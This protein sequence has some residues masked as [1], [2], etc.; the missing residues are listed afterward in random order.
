[1]S[2][3][4]RR[5]AL[6][7]GIGIL[8]GWLSQVQ[9][10]P[11]FA[12]KYEMACK[13]CHM[14]WPTLNEFGR[15]FKMNGYR[16]ES[17]SAAPM[18]MDKRS[19]NLWVEKLPY[20]SAR[21]IGNIYNKSKGDRRWALQPAHE[22]ELYLTG[23][24]ANDVSFFAEVEAEDEAD[25]NVALEN[26]VVGWHPREEANILGGW[27]SIFFADPFN[28]LRDGGGRLTVS[29]K[30]PLDGGFDPDVTG[31]TQFLTFN[32]RTHGLYYSASMGAGG[33]V[34]NEGHD[35]KDYAL[36]LAYSFPMVTFG[37][38]YLD[39]STDLDAVTEDDFT[40]AGLDFLFQKGNWQAYGLW[41][42]TED[43]EWDFTTV[44][45]TPLDEQK[46]TAG[47]VEGMYIFTRAD[48]DPFIVPLV[49]YETVES[50]DGDDETSSVI[51]AVKAYVRSNVDIYLEY[52]KQT[53]V[54]DIAPGVEGEKGRRLTLRANLI[55]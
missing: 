17:G 20:L 8:G 33:D 50:N 21:L 39:G 30:S 51:A 46:N 23:N 55:F 28:T 19:E 45:P 41:M 36:R 53:K 11:A 49:R 31:S 42:T 3:A 48:G 1:M 15:D 52:K 5:L 14:P 22:I 32:G 7:L 13:Q 2:L 4:M 26:L 27:G 35:A 34:T 9:A 43:D 12:R 47:Y 37:G 29:H 38:F 24:P 16:V 25:W 44:P 10:V 40:R 54:P 6:F 18:N